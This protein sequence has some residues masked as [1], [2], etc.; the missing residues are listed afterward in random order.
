MNRLLIC[1]S[2]IFYLNS[3][4]QEKE[5]SFDIRKDTITFYLNKFGDITTKDRASYYRKAKINTSEYTYDGLVKDY[6]L[7][8]Q[9]AFQQSFENGVINGQTIQYY[10]NGKLHHT[11]QYVNS[12]REGKWDYYYDNGRIEKILQYK[13][14]R[15]NLQEF[16]K[17]SGKTVFTNGNGKFRGNI[18]IG[19]KSISS[20]RI[21]GTIKNGQ[22]DGWWEWPDGKEL[23]EDG[24]LIKGLTSW[25]EYNS[26]PA[27]SLTG[28]N[29]HEEVGIFK[30]IAFPKSNTLGYKFSEILSYNNSNNLDEDFKT[31]LIERLSEIN[32][33][34]NSRNYWCFI[35]FNINKNNITN[36][37][38]VHTNNKLISTKLK[39]FIL[40]LKKFDAPNPKNETTECLVYLSFYV[41]N[42]EIVM[43]EYSFYSDIN[44]MD[45]VPKF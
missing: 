31:E 23:F 14:G 17:R 33:K 2:F 32:K 26:N 40:N 27:I 34:T 25:T 38:K 7:N 5:K 15:A 39:G 8:D 9:L 36:D 24:K 16:R 18:I 29:L 3:F 6:F 41:E 20:Y 12:L 30:F 28:F 44:V 21:S 37:I 43:P 35:Q 13:S 19:H 1:I 10:D 45:L 22:P 42:G 11:G 4:S